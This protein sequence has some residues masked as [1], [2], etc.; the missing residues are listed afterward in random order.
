MGEDLLRPYEKGAPMIKELVK[1]EA[2]LSTP[3][4][5]ITHLTLPTN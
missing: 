1:D 3:L 5:L 4:S 2:I